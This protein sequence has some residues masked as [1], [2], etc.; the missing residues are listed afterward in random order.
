[1]TASIFCS[2]KSVADQTQTSAEGS[3]G[4]RGRLADMNLIDLLQAL[5]PGLKTVEITAQSN[6][7]NISNLIIYLDRG[8]DY[9]CRIGRSDRR[10]G[11]L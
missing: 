5:G 1:M 4:A 10:Q 3:F 6:Q 8:A 7:P 11:G 9:I 2:A